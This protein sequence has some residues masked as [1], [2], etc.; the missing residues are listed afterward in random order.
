MSS[1]VNATLYY[2][3]YSICALM[4]RLTYRYRG[5]QA[6]PKRVIV[7]EERD[8]NIFI[9]EQLSEHF[10]CD[11]NAKGEVR[12]SFVFPPDIATIY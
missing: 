10:L 7:V 4:T 11:L 6:D 5:E 12:I 1:Q 3:H 9:G 8:V 2:N